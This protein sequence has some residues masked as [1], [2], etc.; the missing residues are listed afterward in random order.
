MMKQMGFNSEDE[1]M[2]KKYASRFKKYFSRYYII[3]KSFSKLRVGKFI[4]QVDVNQ[5]FKLKNW[6]KLLGYNRSMKEEE[7]E[8]LVEDQLEKYYTKPFNYAATIKNIPTSNPF[9]RNTQEKQLWKDKEK[10]WNS[11]QREKKK[12][13]SF[14]SN[15]ND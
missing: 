9:E 10:L 5:P 6:K 15:L 4:V 12:F 13:R 3:C 2:N 14:R 7:W 11:E 1:R 8:K